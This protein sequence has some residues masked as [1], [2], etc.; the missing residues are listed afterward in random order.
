MM[1]DFTGLVFACTQHGVNKYPDIFWCLAHGSRVV[2]T[3]KDKECIYAQ[4]KE[5]N[6]P[7]DFYL[8]PHCGKGLA[9]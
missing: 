2:A 9:K 3:E 5:S 7:Y 4:A 1:L 8:C 6:D